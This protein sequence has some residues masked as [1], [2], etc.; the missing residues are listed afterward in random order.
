MKFLKQDLELFHGQTKLYN[1]ANMQLVEKLQNIINTKQKE[2]ADLSSFFFLIL[3]D[4]ITKRNIFF[5]ISIFKNYFFA[6]SLPIPIAIIYSI[7]FF[8][9]CGIGYYLYSNYSNI[10]PVQKLAW[11]L[12]LAGGVSNIV[13]RIFFGFVIDW[14]YIYQGVFNLADFFIILGVLILIIPQKEY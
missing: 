4:Q 1:Y 13:E 6:F 12:I 11:T 5:K 3:L 8:V 10:P 14:I 9:L 2:S 7:Y